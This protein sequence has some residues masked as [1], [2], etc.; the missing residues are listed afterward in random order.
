MSGDFLSNDELELAG[1]EGFIPAIFRAEPGSRVRSVKQGL[2]PLVALTRLSTTG[3]LRIARTPR[4]AATSTGDEM[5]GLTV[6]VAGHFRVQQDGRLT[7]LTI[8]DIVFHQARCACELITEARSEIQIIKF[9][10]DLLPPG[11][12][13]VVESVRGPQGRSSAMS[14][15]AHYVDQLGRSAAD[16]TAM[17]RADAGQA[18]IALLVMALRNPD[19]AAPDSSDLVLLDTIKA[20]V[21]SHIREP[22]DVEQLARIH[23]VS[24]RHLYHLFERAD[25]TP[26][27]YIRTQRLLAAY[28]ILVDPRHA[29]LSIRRIAAMTGFPN[30]RTFHRA[31]HQKFGTTPDSWRHDGNKRPSLSSL[32]GSPTPSH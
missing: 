21:R 31:F 2:S 9:S 30:V 23:H 22:L 26:G 3:S 10:R 20:Y 12:R 4:L 14:L 13:N 17:Q 1:R 29:G 6:G 28:N 5:M 15:L 18:A 32:G 24:M 27:F 7:A 11:A 16:L 19:A 8:G 25:T